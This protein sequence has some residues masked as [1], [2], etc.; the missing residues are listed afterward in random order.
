MSYN[1]ENTNHEVLKKSLILAGMRDIENH[2]LNGLSLRRIASECNVSCAAPYR[3]FKS[4]DSLV[5]AIFEYVNGQWLLLK[6]SIV[7][8]YG[9]DTRRTVKELCIATVLFLR[10]NQSFKSIITLEDRLLDSAQIKEKN[11]VGNEITLLVNKLYPTDQEN[12]V[13]F[14]IRSLIY[15]ALNENTDIKVIEKCIDKILS[16]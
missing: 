10:A 12:D 14:L 16:E 13:A 4:K 2:G 5:F 9:D 3:H 8:A 15:G 11:K 1:E 7:S 6:D